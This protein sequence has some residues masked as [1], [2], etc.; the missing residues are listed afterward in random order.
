MAL[1]F[2]AKERF[3]YSLQLL[4]RFLRLYSLHTSIPLGAFGLAAGLAFVGAEVEVVAG[5]EGAVDG[6]QRRPREGESGG[7]YGFGYVEGAGVA[8][9]EEG[10]G[11]DEG[12]QFPECGFSCNADGLGEFLRGFFF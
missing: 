6:G 1:F 5:G 3:Q 2:L 4:R 11:F 9:Q 7:A 8:G 12:R 10:G